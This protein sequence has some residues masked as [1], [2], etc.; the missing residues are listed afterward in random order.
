MCVCLPT[1][2][3]GIDRS[4]AAEAAPKPTAEAIDSKR[5]E[6]GEGKNTPDVF[7]RKETV[8]GGPSADMSYR[9]RE[10]MHVARRGKGGLS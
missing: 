9:G 8:R 4:A 1:G 7:V 10:A 3:V 5:L 6:S 2:A